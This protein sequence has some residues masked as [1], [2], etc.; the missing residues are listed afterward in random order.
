[1][2][3]SVNLGGLESEDIE[4]EERAAFEDIEDQR[5]EI[6]PEL[7][8]IRDIPVKISVEMGRASIVVKELLRM[9]VNQIVEV[10]KRVGEPLAILVND[11]VVARG[12]VVVINDKFGIR[13]TDIVN[14]LEQGLL[15]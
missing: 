13:L 6:P 8:F 11:Q 5:L 12:E 1:M 7:E 10:D 9:K 2:G 3:E 4:K 15:E 14:P